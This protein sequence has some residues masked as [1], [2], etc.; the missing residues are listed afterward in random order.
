MAK[1]SEKSPAMESAI[2]SLFGHD[3]A[4]SIIADRCY[5]APIGCGQAV[6]E[7][8]DAASRKEFTISGLCQSCQDTI[9]EGNE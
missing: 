1:P 2:A 9:F 4:A 8:R 5:P 7:F 3:R 6:G